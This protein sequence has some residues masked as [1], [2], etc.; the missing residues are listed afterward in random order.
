[1]VDRPVANRGSVAVCGHEIWIWIK[2]IQDGMD[3]IGGGEG[4]GE[5]GE[6]I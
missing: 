6:V 5:E 3:V 4:R 2:N 1:M